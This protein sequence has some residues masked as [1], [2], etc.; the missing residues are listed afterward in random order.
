L[1]AVLL[2][3]S[4]SLIPQPPS[5]EEEEQAPATAGGKLRLVKEVGAIFASKFLIMP[6]IGFALMKTPLLAGAAKDPLLMFVLLL[7]TCMPSA[8]NL[9]V[10]LQLQGDRFAAGRMARLLL[11]VYVM[12]VPAMSFWLTKILAFTK[13]L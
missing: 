3:L 5:K 2:V 1:P 13:L 10:I 7:E 11:L 12:G 6:L 9:T 8:Q 4:G